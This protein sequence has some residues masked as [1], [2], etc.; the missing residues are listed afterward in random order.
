MAASHTCPLWKEEEEERPQAWTERDAGNVWLQAGNK[1]RTGQKKEV[2]CVCH[3]KV[4][5]PVR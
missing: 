4:P 3:S 2:G 5:P 1:D